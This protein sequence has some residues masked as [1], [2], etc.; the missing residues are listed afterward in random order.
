LFC[1]PRRSVQPAALTPA[2]ANP[3][4]AA[5]MD[6]ARATWPDQFKDVRTE[7]PLAKSLAWVERAHPAAR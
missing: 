4:V 6:W 1:S 7:K 5:E 3:D 2:P